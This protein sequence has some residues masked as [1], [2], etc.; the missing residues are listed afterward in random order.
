MSKVNFW[1]GLFLSMAVVASAAAPAQAAGPTNNTPLLVNPGA[2]TGGAPLASSAIY[3]FADAADTSNLNLVLPPFGFIFT[4]HPP[5]ALGTTVNLGVLPNTPTVVFGLDNLTTGTSFLANVSDGSVP[6]AFHAFYAGPCTSGATCAATFGIFD[7][8]P[9]APAVIAAIDA[10]GANA[11]TIVG[12]EDLTGPQ[13][14]DWDY[15]DLI[16]VFSNVTSTPMPEP[17]TLALLGVGLAGLG[18]ARRRR[19]TA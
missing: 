8:G 3:A 11:F 7:V 6:N 1:T 12:W 9:L 13:N 15:N 10:T 18:L 19:K 4:N 16:F 2:L 14:S 5:P 17:T